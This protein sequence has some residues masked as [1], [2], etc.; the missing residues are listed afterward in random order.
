MLREPPS[1]IEVE[2]GDTDLVAERAWSIRVPAERLH[3]PAGL[4]QTSGDV[5]ARVAECP[6]YNVNVGDRDPAA[7]S[8]SQLPT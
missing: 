6:R 5:P 4:Q 2:R 8:T 1:I 7:S 3:A